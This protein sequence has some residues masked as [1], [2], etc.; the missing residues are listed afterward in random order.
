MNKRKCDDDDKRQQLHAFHQN[1]VP[2]TE[3]SV[4]LIKMMPPL[5]KI[6]LEAA[7]F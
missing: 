2:S 4:L 7:S 3:T 5:I 1:I 6:L